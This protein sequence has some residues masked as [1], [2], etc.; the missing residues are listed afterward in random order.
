MS[1]EHA[2]KK[3]VNN[4]EIDIFEFVNRIG[5]VLKKW[6][7]AIGRGI[8]ITIV[9]LFKRWIPL[10][11]TII[12]GLVISFILKTFSPTVYTSDLVLRNNTVD[13]EQIIAYINRFKDIKDKSIL[14]EALGI[15]KET[16]DNILNIGAFWIIDLNRDSIPDKVDY[17]NSHNVH[18]TI[19]VRM[20][21]RFDIQVKIKSLQDL[22]NVRNGLI[23]YI[24][25]NQ[26]FQEKNKIRLSQLSESIKRME[27]DLSR[28]DSL[29]KVKYFEE[30][31]QRATQSGGQIVF[32]QGQSITQLLHEDINKLL[33]EKQ[34]MEIELNM[35]S[36]IV[37]VLNDFTIPAKRTNNLSYYAT[38]TL[39]VLL[40]PVLLI[41]IFI[42]RR[43]AIKKILEKY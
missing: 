38:R 4:D 6:T 35:Y 18:D 5:A 23:H 8:L 27:I 15:S 19:D 11:L 33:K 41:M 16:S 31:R 12:M 20:K 21:D 17:Y 37:T 43:E 3:N 25:S 22:N 29:Q 13:N 28:I 42:S 14:T 7:N 34:I 32:N 40:I 1:E 24:N 36:Q 2:T 10:L 39:P 9:F 26:F 30:T